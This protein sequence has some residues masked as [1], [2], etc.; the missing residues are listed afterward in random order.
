MKIISTEQVKEL[1]DKTGV[2]VMQCRKALVEAEGDM[3]KALVILKKRGADVA[4]KKSG[5]TLGAGTIQSYIHGNGTIGAIVELSSETDFVAKNEEFK[6]AA[7]DIA[8]HVAATNPEFLSVDDK[9][10][11]DKDEAKEKA[12]LEQAFIKNPD[13]NI[14]DFVNSL[15]QKFGEKIEI[16]RFVRFATSD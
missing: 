3:E 10:V 6:K 1:R 4:A 7:Y 15:I 9:G 2:S 5:R 16:R 11:S 13:I 12:L 14:R 8:M